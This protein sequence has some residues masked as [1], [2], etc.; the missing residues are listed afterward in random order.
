MYLPIS[1]QAKLN[2]IIPGQ[3]RAPCVKGKENDSWV[4]RLRPKLGRIHVDRSLFVVV[5]FSFLGF[6]FSFVNLEIWNSNKEIN[7]VSKEIWENDLE[8]WNSNKKIN[9]V[10]VVYR[11]NLNSNKE[12]ALY[13]ILII[14]E[15]LWNY[16]LINTTKK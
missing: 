16:F 2:V 1:A 6:G 4:D 8:M 15:K 3:C 10:K 7:M 5:I 11:F 12:K 13:I 9:M 14:S